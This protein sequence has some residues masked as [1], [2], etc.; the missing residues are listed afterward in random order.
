[1]APQGP[2][3]AEELVAAIEG[4]AGSTFW[5]EKPHLLTLERVLESPAKV[6]ELRRLRG[7]K[8]WRDPRPKPA[9]VPRAE[10]PVPAADEAAKAEAEAARAAL[11]AKFRT[12]VTA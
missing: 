3:Q 5:R 2:Y 1:V 10:A 12:G 4:A 9:P 11:R 6:D 8:G 7:A